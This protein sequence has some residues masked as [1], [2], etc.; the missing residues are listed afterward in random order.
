[1]NDSFAKLKIC[2][3]ALAITPFLIVALSTVCGALP[4]E[5]KLC[6]QS[7]QAPGLTPESKPK[8]EPLPFLPKLDH[9]LP[10]AIAAYERGKFVQ[11]EELFQSILL[12]DM[13]NARAHYYYA[14]CLAKDGKRSA[15]AC[16]YEQTLKYSHDKNLTAYSLQAVRNL[17][18]DAAE[19]AKNQSE[20]I[21]DKAK[22]HGAT[23]HLDMQAERLLSQLNQDYE[24][25]KKEWQRDLDRSVHAAEIQLAEDIVARPG[26][27][28][29]LE[30]KAGYKI[31][32]IKIDAQEPLKLIEEEH[33]RKLTAFA[34]VHENLKGQMRARVGA[35]Q[36][37]PA[38]TNLTVRNY[39]NFGGIH[40]PEP[41]LEPVSP[42]L[43]ATAHSL[44][45]RL[46]PAQSGHGRQTKM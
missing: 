16:E 2:L 3:S 30:T 33:A 19:K 10:A 14:S 39:I 22:M 28:S 6:N 9:D 29:D 12:K 36:V 8:P 18:G 43:K 42:G 31:R 7:R 35:S 4:P 11:A 44:D 25:K 45:S 24:H 23:K 17:H 26:Q 37:V 1:M 5:E 40:E 20:S 41:Q 38:N 32:I 15:A 46:K 27:K 21:A 13:S 34:S